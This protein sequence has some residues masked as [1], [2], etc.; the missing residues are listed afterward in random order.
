MRTKPLA[1][2]SLAVV[3]ATALLSGGLAAGFLATPAFADGAATSFS[4]L[5]WDNGSTVKKF[6]VSGSGFPTPSPLEQLQGTSVATIVFTPVTLDNPNEV[7]TFWVAAKPGDTTSTSVSADV[8]LAMAPTGQY[9]VQVGDAN[10]ANLSTAAPAKFVIY[11]FGSANA[12]KVAF[13]ATGGVDR[14]PGSLDITG[15]NI[16]IGAKVNFSLPDGSTDPNPK[17]TFVQGNPNQS[18]NNLGTQDADGHAGSGY[19]SS[20]LLQGN[21]SYA[22]DS[23][24][25]VTPG[26]TPGLRKL[27]IVNN[28]GRT[29]GTRVDF[30]QPWFASPTSSSSPLSPSGVGV[31]ASNLQVTLTGQGIRAGSSLAIESGAAG[32]CAGVTVGASTVSSPDAAHAGTYTKITAPVSMADCATNDTSARDVTINGPD[33]GYFVRT[34]IFTI[35]ANPVFDD[36]TLTSGYETLG[37]GARVGHGTEVV[38]IFGTGFEGDPAFV[39]VPGGDPAKMTKFSFGQ[40]V[41][42]VD[43]VTVT[44]VLVGS[45]FAQVRIDV[46]NDATVGDRTLS[47]INPDG[48][49][50]SQSGAPPSV[51][52]LNG[53]PAPLT[54]AAGPKVTKVQPA[55][56]PR[57][58]TSEPTTVTVTGSFVST[59]TYTAMVCD[60]LDTLDCTE[61]E[62]IN[63]AGF[64]PTATTL[65]FTV[66]TNAA[67]PGVR[68]LLVTDLTNKGRFYCT[69]CIGIDSLT[70][71]A[72]T[73]VPNTGDAV[74][75]LNFDADFGSGTATTASSAT[76]TRLVTLP[77]QGP[78]SLKTGTTLVPGAA[79]SHTATGTFDVRDIAP[80]QYSI[81]VVKDPTSQSSP[82]WSCNGCLTVTG[83]AITTTSIDR[84]PTD[85][86]DP[87]STSGGQGATNLTITIPGTNYSKGMQVAIPDV[88]VDDNSVVVNVATDVL[89]FTVHVPADATPG[90][91]TVTV[92]AGDGSGQNTGSKAENLHFVVTAAPAPSSATSPAAYGQGAGTAGFLAANPGATVTLSIQGDNFLSGAQLSLGPLVDVTDETV[93]QGC[94]PPDVGCPTDPTPDVLTAKVSVAEGATPGKRAAVVTNPDGG[95][96]SRAESFTVSAGPTI[97]SV[98]N[99][100]GNPVLAPDGVAHPI[101]VLGSGFATASDL[102]K[103]LDVLPADGVTITHV[104]VVDAGKITAEVKVDTTAALGARTVGVTND[105]DKGYGSITP[106]YVAKAPGTP[107][108]LTLVAGGSSLKATWTASAPNGAPVTNYHLSIQRVGTAL[109]LQADTG[110]ALT[111]TFSA[112]ANGA[113]YVVRVQAVNAAGPGAAAS[114]TGIPGLVTTLSSA[115]SSKLITAG[116]AMAIGGK[117]LHGTTPVPSRYIYVRFAPSVGAAYTKRVLT[118]STGAWSYH[119]V[120]KY[121]FNVRATFTGDNVYRAASGSVLAVSVRS[122]I[123]R[124]APTNGST[125]SASTVLKI[126][127]AVYPNHHGAYVYLYRYVSGKKTFVT[128]TLVTSTSTYVFS[129]KPRRG[130]YTFRVYIPNTRGNV[131]NYTTAFTLKRV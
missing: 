42:G 67:T 21:Y 121:T 18:T 48:G 105:S 26:F 58:T 32:S 28:D 112:L 98:S 108:S 123:V 39:G 60:Q 46:T 5:Q 106:V 55:G 3:T 102:S 84:V 91:K 117:L 74:L 7:S 109:V 62:N 8:N 122:R 89:T 49:T 96:G 9:T 111:K 124:T 119:F 99:A 31:G 33:G 27:Q 94:V 52:N 65:T 81:T 131:A 79:G 29:G 66:S 41:Q 129:I 57:S 12:T 64:T 14:G 80:G 71:G 70:L 90:T 19:A 56:L 76:L 77:G 37:Q 40:G 73:S 126:K 82:T 130:S 50:A 88:T 92:T 72:P 61:S 51:S 95:S 45:G 6:S 34:G 85:G 114:K 16:A 13:G 127:G 128:R 120:T 87:L 25:G 10:H 30:A 107:G 54:I 35:A 38:K 104:A 97:A 93:T 113:S 118:S 47:A 2:R 86:S 4:P 116:S 44:T 69:G 36:P 15:S 23:V 24:A 125:S 83:A 101:T 53:T 78:I 22:P 103:V 11:G 115:V 17:L 68:D 1:R 20:T 110:T 43:G 75:N 59:D 100:A 63:E